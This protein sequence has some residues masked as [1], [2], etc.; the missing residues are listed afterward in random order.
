VSINWGYFYLAARPESGMTQRMNSDDTS[1]TTFVNT[2]KLPTSDDN[3]M[4]RLANDHWPVLA[5]V[6]DLG[7]IPANSTAVTKVLLLAYDDI[8]SINY[9]GQM[10]KGYWTQSSASISMYHIVYCHYD[11]NFVTKMIYWISHTENIRHWFHN[12]QCLISN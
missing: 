10:L 9:F 6:W 1:R 4:P 5:N 3:N 8:Y 7:S 11:T 12:V 2:G